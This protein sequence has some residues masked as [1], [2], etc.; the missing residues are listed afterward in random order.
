MPTPWA[1]PSR[2][3]LPC[4]RPS[5]PSEPPSAAGSWPSAASA[6][7]TCSRWMSCIARSSRVAWP[8]PRHEAR[9][10]ARAGQG[11]PPL[12][13][14]HVGLPRAVRVPGLA[15]YL[16]ALPADRHR[17]GLEPDPA[18]P[19]DDRVHDRLRPAGQPA[20]G[21]GALSDPGL[22]RAAALAVLLE[23]ADGLQQQPDP[24]RQH[25]LEDLLPA[26]RPARQLD[27]R[28]LRR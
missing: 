12:L 2:P 15:R 1:P 5:W 10:R 14:R 25:D 4:P 9:N 17:G 16:G 18:A 11:L 22:R 28:Q 6:G 8:E 7:R 21:W 20:I 19:H 3:P 27:H 26:D 24:E 13:A 23:W